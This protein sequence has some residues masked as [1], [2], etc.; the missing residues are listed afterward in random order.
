MAAHHF[1]GAVDLLDDRV[2][3][4]LQVVAFEEHR[5]QQ[6]K[7][8]ARDELLEAFALLLGRADDL[9]ITAHDAGAVADVQQRRLRRKEA[10]R[11]AA[12]D[13]LA[14]EPHPPLLP[15]RFGVGCVG[16]PFVGEEHH[17]RAGLHGRGGRGGRAEFALSRDDVEQLVFAEHAPPR[18]GE[19]VAVGMLRQG[20]GAAGR[21]VLVPRRGADDAPPLVV[22]GDGQVVDD[23]LRERAH[24]VSDL[25]SNLSNVI[26]KIILSSVFLYQ[27]KTLTSNRFFTL[28]KKI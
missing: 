5:T 4:V 10:F 12:V 23:A 16:V 25:K 1:A 28:C 9:L 8:D 18:A 2:V 20:I 14:A 15:A 26:T 17:H 19:R 3:E 11:H 22:V 27:I 6:V 7:H 21:N 13:V 24:N